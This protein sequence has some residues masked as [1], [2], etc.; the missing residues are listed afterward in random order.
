MKRFFAL[1]LVL[2]MII[3]MVV[4]CKKDEEESSS[5]TPTSSSTSEDPST[6][7]PSSTPSGPVGGPP[8]NGFS[9][10]E[11]SN[12]M[13]DW[14]GKTLRVL[15]TKYGESAN[16]PWGQVELC[17]ESFGTGMK[18]AFDDREAE[19]LNRYGVTVDWVPAGAPQTV[20]QDL[21]DA[22]LSE[23]LT[24]DIAIPRI[25]EVQSLVSSVYNMRESDYLDFN[26]DYFSLNAY[27]AFTVSGYTLFAA[28]G[29]DFAD[30]HSS[31]TM[32]VNKE[33]LAQ[34]A[35]S[36]DL[37]KE[38]RNGNWTY[39]SLVSISTL[40][41]GDANGDGLRDDN[42]I[43][44][45]G[46]KNVTRYFYYFGVFEADV[47]P[48]NGMYRFAFDLDTEK[49]ENIINLMKNAESS[50]WAR[51]S[52]W[53]GDWGSAMH[54][55]FEQGRLL[56]FNDVTQKVSE[57][58]INFEFGVIPFPKLNAEQENYIVPL[59]SQQVTV[60]CIPRVTQDR[61]MSEYFVDVLSWTGADYTVQA[62][63]DII[64]GTMGLET[65]EEDM[66]IMVDYVFANMDYDIGN[67][68]AGNASTLMGSIKEDLL[69]D[70]NFTTIMQEQGATLAEKVKTWND[71]W[72]GYD[73]DMEE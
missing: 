11:E 38:V 54:T 44:G 1:I 23:T 50:E 42:D 28:G 19:I 4:A 12:V 66:E 30:E 61:Q 2:L 6:D 18:K 25:F 73:G 39:D 16:W 7:D 36:A 52:N 46:T 64:Q 41:K 31:Y 29:H 8:K 58:N 43:Y 53:G 51:T 22:E 67:I 14:S 5:S 48:D 32:L 15:V 20:S 70:A 3:P 21:A 55:A 17:A 37:Y 69:G 65:S 35:P 63:Y 56:F 71:A 45:F 33:M 60:I 72:A 13:T 9:S 49:V 34:K 10:K 47:D 24:Y 62:Y 26:N 59:Q 57:L 68:T 40:V 27:E